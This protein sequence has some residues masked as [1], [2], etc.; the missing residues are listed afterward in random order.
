VAAAAAV[1]SA[2]GAPAGEPLLFVRDGQQGEQVIEVHPFAADGSPRASDF[3]LLEAELACGSGHSQQ[4]EAA[5]VRLLL[6]AQRDF[7]KPLVLIGGRCPAHGDHPDTAAH[8]RAGRAVD[9]R[10]RGVSS[11]QLMTW[12]VKRGVGGAGRYKRAGFVHVD[13]RT[14]PRE[15]WQAE[16]PV[17][18]RAKVEPEPAAPS[19]V[20]E[21]APQ[22][23]APEPAAPAPPQD[24]VP[25]PVEN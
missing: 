23:I 19:E 20:G 11:E 16:E 25:A 18:Q 10:M 14:G 9:M 3:A 15:Q 4:P 17:P 5:L 8:H 2:D 22:A 21:A 24:G 6:E 13:L 12:L 1:P 7:G